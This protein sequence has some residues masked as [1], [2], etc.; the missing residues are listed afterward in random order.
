MEGNVVI[1]LSLQSLTLREKSSAITDILSMDMS[2]ILKNTC[3]KERH[4]TTMFVLRD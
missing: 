3:M 4:T 1:S 2:F